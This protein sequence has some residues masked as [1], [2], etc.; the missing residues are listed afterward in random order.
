VPF[1]DIGIRNTAVHLRKNS[2]VFPELSQEPSFNFLEEAWLR[3]DAQE[4]AGTQ[5]ENIYES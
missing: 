5:Y 4:A 2:P 1:S 3:E